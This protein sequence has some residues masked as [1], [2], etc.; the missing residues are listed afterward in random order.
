MLLVHIIGTARD[1]S[2]I[3]T[4]PDKFSTLIGVELIKAVIHR[5]S[6]WSDKVETVLIRS[7]INSSD[8]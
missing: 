4:D 2:I 1:A 3:E 7:T 6:R 8:T 5:V